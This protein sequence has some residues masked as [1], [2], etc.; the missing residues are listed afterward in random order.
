MSKAISGRSRRSA[1]AKR[2]ILFYVQDSW[3]L[4]HIQ[5]V[6]KLAR[7]VQDSAQCLILCGH[8]EAGQIVP[9]GCEYIRIPSLNIPLS[10]GSGGVFWGRQSPWSL[11][12]GEAIAFRHRVIV[13]ALEAFHPDVVVV[14][15]RPLGMMNELG[16][17]LDATDAAKIFLTRGIMTHPNRVRQHYLGP[18]QERALRASF[19]RIV[20]AADRRVWDF[21]ANYGL[22]TEIANKIDYVGYMS[23]P[24]GASEIAMKRAERGLGAGGRWIVC[25]AGGGALGEGLIEAFIGIAG[26]LGAAAV[27]IVFGPHSRL[28]WPAGA[29]PSAASGDVRVHKECTSL[30]LLH[31]AADVIV[32]PGGYNSLMECMEGGGQI[33]AMPVQPDRDG[34]QYLLSSQLARFYPVRTVSTAGELKRAIEAMVADPHVKRS[35]RELGQLNFDGLTRARD[36]LLTI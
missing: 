29:C 24:I 26:S 11:A 22:D 20:V 5:R 10:Q 14:E 34:E 1:P 23:E 18:D 4:G 17:I 33:V 27:D 25:S 3:G 13:G 30:A 36:I 2:R 8:R 7:A 28:P 19:D 35:V 9:D 15:N 6:S 31:A 32:C 16:P 21:A 12:T